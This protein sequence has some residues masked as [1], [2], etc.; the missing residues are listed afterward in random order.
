ENSITLFSLRMSR[1]RLRGLAVCPPM[2]KCPPPTESGPVV[3]RTVSTTSSTV[4]GVTTACTG[5]GF[6]RVTSFTMISGGAFMAS[7]RLFDGQIVPAEIQRILTVPIL[8][9][10]APPQSQLGERPQR[11]DDRDEQQEQPRRMPAPVAQPPGGECSHDPEERR[12][13]EGRGW[14]SEQPFQEDEQG[15]END[16]RQERRPPRSGRRHG[17]PEREQQAAKLFKHV[18]LFAGCGRQAA[19]AAVRPLRPSDSHLRRAGT[20]GRPRFCSWRL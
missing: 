10:R 19:R 14:P 18:P 11:P 5:T 1:W 4:T 3:L 8:A 17:P 6:R 9:G 20:R 15:D 7:R 13:K 12:G 16:C 2:L